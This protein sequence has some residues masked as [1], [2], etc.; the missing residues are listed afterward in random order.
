MALSQN[1]LTPHDLTIAESDD[2]DYANDDGSVTVAAN[3]EKIICEFRPGSADQFDLLA[4]AATD[5]ADTEYVLRSGSDIVAATNS[6]LGQIGDPFSFRK[7]YGVPLRVSRYA[8]LA[9]RNLG[10]GSQDYVARL[11]C[12]VP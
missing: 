3:E 2:L 9:V 11:H 8:T 1:P 5:N 6:A 4:M 12:E 7:E 10:T